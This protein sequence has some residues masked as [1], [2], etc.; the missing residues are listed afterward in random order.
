MLPTQG[1]NVQDLLVPGPE[2]ELKLSLW[3]IGGEM[4]SRCCSRSPPNST[5][6]DHLTSDSCAT[7][8][9]AVALSHVDACLTVCICLC[10]CVVGSCTCLIGATEA[11][12]GRCVSPVLASV[13]RRIARRGDSLRPRSLS[14]SHAA[15]APPSRT[16]LF[17][18]RSSCLLSFSH[19]TFA[20]LASPLSQ[21][22]NHSNCSLCSLASLC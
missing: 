22:I 8:V 1:T 7:L 17:L 3:E 11:A 16:A 20:S 6:A 2:Y 12:A 10:A 14:M 9:I 4:T 5:P 13:F 18:I 15:T 21:A 19:A